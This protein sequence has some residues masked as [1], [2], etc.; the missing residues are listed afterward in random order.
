[1]TRTEMYQA[2][3]GKKVACMEDGLITEVGFF[4]KGRMCFTV[5]HF[6]P[7]NRIEH[8]STPYSLRK[9]D[10]IEDFGEYILIRRGTYDYLFIFH[11]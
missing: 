9:W 2:L 3:E 5:K 4:H 7:L 11:E 1:M 6:K 8:D 10:Y